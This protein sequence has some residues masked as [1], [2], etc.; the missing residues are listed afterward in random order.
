M[1]DKFSPKDEK[2]LVL[3][4][5]CQVSCCTCCGWFA[6]FSITCWYERSLVPCARRQVSCPI[7]CQLSNTAVSRMLC[8]ATCPCC[9]LHL[10]LQTSG[11]SLTAQEPYNN[12]IRT[13]V[14]VSSVPAA[15]KNRCQLAAG[16]FL[17]VPL[18][19]AALELAALPHSSLPTSPACS[20]RSHSHACL[21]HRAPASPA[22]PFIIGDAP[23][24]ELFWM[25]PQAMAAVL[26]GTQSL[27]TNSFDE[28][29]PAAALFL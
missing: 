5:H 21:L 19:H 7:V 10:T 6:A 11:Y 13:T 9:F 24:L 15:T 3:R 1:K 23:N 17:H 12:I 18:L 20:G 22:S 26:G 8:P 27:H 25:H 29:G 4:T 28:V 16:L 14:E 2:S